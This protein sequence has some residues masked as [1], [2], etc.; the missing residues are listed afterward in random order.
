[1]STDELVANVILKATGEL[2]TAS[3]GDDDYSKVLQL[4]NLNIDKWA[5]ED[6]WTSLYDSVEIGTVTATDTFDLDDTIRVV[7]GDPDDPVEIL[8]TGGQKVYFQTVA[9]SDL[10]KY[11]SGNYCARVGQSIKFNRVFKSTD[12]EY[13]GTII[14]PAYLYAEHLTTANSTVPV[15][16]PSWLVA[17]TAADWVQLD[18]TLAQNRPDFIAEANDLMTSMQRHNRP[19][20]RTLTL[21]PL[22]FDMRS[23]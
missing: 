19:Q 12:I 21:S 10:K 22:P 2:S 13:G 3:F 1:M 16:D 14:V 5:K 9:P 18:A 15:D 8:T 17:M 11:S 23:W 4:A 20:V 6:N 7:S